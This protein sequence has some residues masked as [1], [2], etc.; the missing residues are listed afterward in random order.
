MKN[1]Y[2]YYKKES[3]CNIN[4]NELMLESTCKSFLQVQKEGNRNVK[5]I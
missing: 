2:D 4:N 5:E 1:F 3:R